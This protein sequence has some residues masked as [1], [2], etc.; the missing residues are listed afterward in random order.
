[1]TINEYRQ[2]AQQTTY[3]LADDLCAAFLERAVEGGITREEFF[4]KC[5]DLEL[6]V[7]IYKEDRLKGAMAASWARINMVKTLGI[8][9][10][11]EE[12][13]FMNRAYAV[14]LGKLAPE[15]MF[16]ML[17]R[18]DKKHQTPNVQMEI[19]NSCARMGL[20]VNHSRFDLGLTILGENN[21]E[22][23]TE[24]EI[25]DLRGKT[26]TLSQSWGITW[27]DL[28]KEDIDHWK[29]PEARE[30]EIDDFGFEEDEGFEQ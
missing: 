1:M 18:Y 29:H 30:N 10:N 12:K 16:S 11:L 6:P 27:S 5:G 4:E 26:S 14:E 17:T 25:K 9:F 19:D 7:D 24:Y 22:G 23:F 21:I 3:G 28:T 20:L 2:T 15:P 13:M 8:P